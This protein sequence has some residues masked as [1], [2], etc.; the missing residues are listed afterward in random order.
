MA[1][2][3]IIEV[4]TA[5]PDGLSCRVMPGRAFPRPA[6]WGAFGLI[7]AFS[8][9]IRSLGALR[10]SETD[11][12]ASSGNSY[13]SSQTGRCRPRHFLESLENRT[14]SGQRLRPKRNQVSN[15]P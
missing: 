1:P 2:I 3:D 12:A 6:L 7:S 9:A 11:R 8:S 14:G 13:Q 5:L 15:T 10:Q 4:F